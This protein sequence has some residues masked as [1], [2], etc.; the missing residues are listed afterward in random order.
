MKFYD[1]ILC[2]IRTFFSLNEDTTEAEIDNLLTQEKR[3]L[4]E[5]TGG[6]VNEEMQL[7]IQSLTTRM[8]NMEMQMQSKDLLISELT[9]MQTKM[10]SELQERENTILLKQG[11]I[12]ALNLSHKG[13]V[14]E[15]AGQLATLKA[16]NATTDNSFNAAHGVALLKEQVPQNIM[17]APITD[18]GLRRNLGLPKL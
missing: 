13:K 9:E 18:A 15:L 14:A 1:S 6:S 7:S 4:S 16:G 8:E 11:E 2:S 17:A 3:T 10:T 12:D 5:I